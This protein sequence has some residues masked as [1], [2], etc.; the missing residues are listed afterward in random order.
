MKFHTER[1]DIERVGVAAETEFTIKTTA[2]AFDILSSGL[3]TDNI[4]AI[5]R[6]LSCNASDSHVDAGKADTPFEIHLPNRLEPF[7]SVKDFGT[8]LSDED[9]MTLYT[10]YFE[11]TKTNSNDFIGALGLGSKSP[12]S[13]T[14]AFEVISRFEGT[15]RVYSVFI[16]EDGVPTIARLGKPIATDEPNGL[17]VKLAVDES[18][19]YKFK[20]K[21]GSALRWFETKPTVVGDTYFEFD[22]P[23]STDMQGDGWY[24]H[25][26]YSSGNMLAVQGHVE[27]RVNINQIEE[28]DDSVKTFL[29]TVNVIAFFD[30]GD[31]EVAANREE[32]RYD[33]RTREALAKKVESIHRA[34]LKS[35]E[36]KA[37]EL[38]TGMWDAI[39]ELNQL[40]G[41]MFNDAAKFRQF[42][43]ISEH[44][45]LQA[46]AKSQGRV[47]LAEH[48]G[49]EVYAYSW[50]R[51]GRNLKRKKLEGGLEPT[52]KIHFWINDMK[53]G[54]VGRLTNW[55]KTNSCERSIVIVAKKD[56]FRYEKAMVDGKEEMVR[57]NMTD[58]DVADE[59]KELIDTFGNPTIKLTS[60]DTTAVPRSPSARLKAIFR[61]SSYH[62][63]RHRADSV[64]WDRVEDLDMDAGGL[65]FMLERGHTIR[66]KGDKIKWDAD[67]VKQQLEMMTDVVNDHLGLSDD[68]LYDVETQ[69]IGVGALDIKKFEKHQ[70]WI[71]IF[72]LFVQAIP[73]YAD[74]ARAS[75]EWDATPNV[76]NIKRA[77]AE[78][79]FQK[80]VKELKPDSP[81]RKLVE[82]LEQK[83][84]HLES[85]HLTHTAEVKEFDWR[86]G[87]HSMELV[88]VKGHF[89]EDALSMYPM[90]EF[91]KSIEC[92]N[93]YDKTDLAKLFE[94]IKLI[95]GSN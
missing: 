42:V 75:A 83:R 91:V 79:K 27:Y 92:R 19:F 32:I 60:R 50:A 88:D 57:V 38:T 14:N 72:D 93:V 69:V 85:I 56:P 2:K 28:I 24:I 67:E 33:R 29:K 63:N 77:Y 95:D 20:T 18:D 39:I 5:V 17:E 89:E 44:P 84:A 51:Y 37:D 30:I 22:T 61:Y 12:F 7:F 78:P 55:M 40:A 13:Y 52:R 21:T 49:H 4:Y 76:H 47:K 15:R 9:V 86:Y 82:L 70:G 94:Y 74:A 54:G 73:K 36:D 10:T 43:R 46:Y 53:T 71:N 81:L 68:N 41:S 26:G 87:N 80:H 65:Y 62:R 34:A 48:D 90:L 25:K 23:P 11:S 31:L 64:E 16:N 1:A 45:V 58:T 3:Y 66:W 35:I 59:L 8:G 6:E